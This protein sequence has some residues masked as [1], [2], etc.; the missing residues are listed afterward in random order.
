MNLNAFF[1]LSVPLLLA[2]LMF[3]LLGCYTDVETEQVAEPKVSRKL[4]SEANDG[5]YVF[6]DGSV[7]EGELVLGLPNGFGT[8]EFVSGNI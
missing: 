1:P 4:S 6:E 3:S 8:L 5:R 7:Y 2:G